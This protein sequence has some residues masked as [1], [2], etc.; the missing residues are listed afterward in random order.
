ME[1]CTKYEQM[2]VA[3]RNC[4][5]VL[6]LE[7]LLELAYNDDGISKQ[8]YISLHKLSGNQALYIMHKNDIKNRYD[9][10]YFDGTYYEESGYC[11]IRFHSG[12]NTHRYK[13]Y[14]SGKGLYFNSYGIR[15]YFERKN[16]FRSI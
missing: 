14:K 3:M 4:K 2:I 12:F 6:D 9:T 13:V 15:F 7:N 16:L 1:Y 8:E 10:A 5:K 11:E